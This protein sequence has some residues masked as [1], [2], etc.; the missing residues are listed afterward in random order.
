MTRRRQTKGPCMYCH[1]EMTRNGM[2]RH[3]GSCAQRQ[4]LDTINQAGK[5]HHREKQYH[6]QVQDA[7][8]LGHWLQLEIRGSARLTDLDDYLR[9]IWL[10]CC[11]HL[12]LFTIR[13]KRY[14]QILPDPFDMVEDEQSMDVRVDRILNTGLEIAYEYDFGSTTELALKVVGQR[15]GWRTTRNAVAL[16]ARNKF[17][18][19]PCGMCDKPAQWMCLDCYYSNDDVERGFVCGDDTAAH[20][21]HDEYGSLMGIFNSPRSGVCG[22]D[23]PAEPPY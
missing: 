13:G 16:M 7:H 12:S 8:G 11:G 5:R 1:E 3:L 23:G 18:P 10:E 15:I 22:Y 4:R 21:E 19:P 20:S 6:L 17:E 9:G 2:V 14:T